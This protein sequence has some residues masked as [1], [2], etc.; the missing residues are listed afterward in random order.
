[1][2]SKPFFIVINFVNLMCWQ[3]KKINIMKK[4]MILLVV[5]FSAN[6]MFAQGC[7]MDCKDKYVLNNNSIEATL[8]HDNGVIAQKGSYTLDNKLQ[9]K[10][11]SY[12]AE[13][14]K[15]AIAE[16]ANG[17][18][19]GT[20]YFFQ[21]EDILKEVTYANNGIAQVKTWQQTDTRVVGNYK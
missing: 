2:L 10:W 3:V 12:D 17:K 7:K 11:I 1:M 4:L 9:G 16:Y 5:V 15:T 6:A 8:Y 21:G 14:K 13:G 20:W 19:V 18:K